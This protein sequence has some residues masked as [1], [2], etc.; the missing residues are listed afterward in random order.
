M[1]A[2]IRPRSDWMLT[3]A[4]SLRAFSAVTECVDDLRE[5][6]AWA[7][8]LGF[9]RDDTGARRLR[10][11]NT[12]AEVDD[13][14][15]KRKCGRKRRRSDRTDKKCEPE[16]GFTMMSVVARFSARAVPQ[17]TRKPVGAPFSEGK[18]D[19]SRR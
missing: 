18:H 2:L 16:H 8:D 14:G 12:L 11:E 10:G 4:V 9:R 15:R 3:A 17:G 13:R 5:R 6:P 19:G 1:R 7:Q